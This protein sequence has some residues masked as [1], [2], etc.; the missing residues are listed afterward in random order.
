MD[1]EGTAAVLAYYAARDEREWLRLTNPEGGIIEFALTCRALEKHLPEGGRV[2]DLGCGPGRYA[3]WLAQ[4]GYQVTLADLSPNLLEVAREKLREAGVMQNVEAIEVADARDLS[5]W[6]SEGFDA[7]LALGPFY[8]LQQADDRAAAARELHRVLKPSAPAFVA[9]MPI[10][11]LLRRTMSLPE[12][13]HLL[14]DEQWLHALRKQGTYNNDAP[15]R[16]TSV[17][18]VQPSAVPAFFENHGFGSR[19]LL[20]LQSLSVGIEPGLMEMA[21]LQ[22]EAYR[23]ALDLLEDAAADPSTHGLCGHLLYIGERQGS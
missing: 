18:G 10:Y 20:G 9:T 23:R 4:R 2:L 3:I 16:F 11:G 7:A 13:H 12:E 17:Q 22:P 15:G 6:E 14:L 21:R 5:A 1:D 19:A 8:H